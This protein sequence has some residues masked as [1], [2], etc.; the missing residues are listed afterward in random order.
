MKKWIVLLI[1]T[2]FCTLASQNALAT[3]STQKAHPKS[4]ASHSKSE[5]ASMGLKAFGVQVGMVSPEDIDATAGFGIFA[6]WGTM[7][8]N[9]RLKSHLD[10]W[11]ASEDAPF[12]GEATLRDV[13]LTMR[14]H[15]LFPVT[16]PRFQPFVGAGLGLHFLNAKVEVPGYPNVEDSSTKLGLDFGGGFAAPIS[17][18]TDFTTELWYG[19][20]DNANQLSLKV[21]MA[22]KM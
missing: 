20:V 7:A 14:G 11:S 22:F 18:K 8:P 1:A 19:V 16:S 5:G 6:D 17:P 12:G 15:Y 21:G 4:R 10:Y 3:P 2:G 13:A 9:F